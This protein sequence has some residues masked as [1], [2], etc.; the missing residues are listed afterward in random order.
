MKL[1]RLLFLIIFIGTVARFAVSQDDTRAVATWQVQKY[2]IT[3]TLPTTDADRNLSAKANLTVKNVSSSSASTLSLR[4][5]PNATVSAITINGT[6]ADFTKREDPIGNA[7][8]LQRIAIR[9]PSTAP[10]ATVTA[11]VDYKLNVKDNT[12]LGAISPVGA[13]FLPLSFW[14]PTPNS[15]YFERGA[16]Y[17]GFQLKV[18][19]P[20][21]QTLVSSGTE[22]NGAFNLNTNGQPFFLTGSWDATNSSGVTVLAPKGL[23]ADAKTRADE[24]AKLASDA[25]AFMASF[26]GPAP[27]TPLRIVATRRGAGYSQAGTILVDEGVFR[28]SKID[29]LTA[30]NIAE[31]VA[32]LWIGGSVAIAGDGQGAIR[33]GLPRF[34]ATEFIESKFGKDI[35]DIERTRQ[36]VA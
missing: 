25:K 33:E 31:A 20:V 9:I 23:A 19:T 14:Y 15:W 4:I 29:S 35:A 18:N 30:M 27:D 3:A 28:R 22:T 32:K 12:G 8:T 11:S 16:D 7:G 1:T 21:G 13:I 24:L 34:L 26:L 36:R 17:S 5:S 2:D 6:T 10:G